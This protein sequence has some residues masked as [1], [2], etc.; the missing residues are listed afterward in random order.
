[1]IS[2]VRTTIATPTLAP[3]RRYKTKAE[4]AAIG[5]YVLTHKEA[6]GAGLPLVIRATARQHGVSESTIRRAVEEALGIATDPESSEIA[7]RTYEP[8]RE[9]Y[10]R[11]AMQAGNVRAAYDELKAEGHPGLPSYETVCRS[12]RGDLGMLVAMR[13]GMKAFEQFV[14]VGIYEADVRNERALVDEMH[15]P[16][17]CRD[18]YGKVIEDLWLISIYDDFARMN[19]AHAVT[20]GAVTDEVAEAVLYAAVMGYEVPADELAALGITWLD[21]AGRPT[22]G[23]I[24][25]VPDVLTPDHAKI[26]EGKRFKKAMEWVGT[27]PKFARAHM[28]VDKAKLERFHS[29]LQTKFLAGIP[30]FLD[31]PVPHAIDDPSVRPYAVPSDDRL[32]RV[33]AVVEMIDKVIADYNRTHVVSTTGQTPFERWFSANTPLRKIEPVLFWPHMFPVPNPT[34]SGTNVFRVH[35]R[36]IYVDGAFR[37]N[38]ALGPQIGG[39]VAVRAF[40]GQPG[41]VFVSKDGPDGNLTCE[42]T[43]TAEMDETGRAARAASNGAR[44]HRARSY[45]A[46]AGRRLAADGI[47]GDAAS[48]EP[49][50]GGEAAPMALRGPA[51]R[52]RADAADVGP[53]PSAAMALPFN[54]PAQIEGA[55]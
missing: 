7:A 19:V 5:R 13:K 31:G 22:A 29:T 16:I 23:F 47:P 53:D 3:V 50:A 40:P 52:R 10:V 45:L 20:R 24:G 42:V 36:G 25:G 32:P 9:V 2:L 55:A 28:A 35:P 54:P 41:R 48:E 33:E 4:R 15:V 39:M 30:G 17:R 46:E 26:Y 6:T 43:S 51:P 37:T 21:A 18:R 27:E 8:C 44:A 38:R 34:T 49:A 12:L 11:T 1:M 14:L